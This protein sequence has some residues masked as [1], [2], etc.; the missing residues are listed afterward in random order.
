MT[1]AVILGLLGAG[2]AFALIALVAVVR[3]LNVRRDA[4]EEWR[5]RRANGHPSVDGVD[6]ARFRRAYLRAHGPR[7]QFYVL[8]AVAAA[9][10]STPVAAGP[11]VWLWRTITPADASV[12]PRGWSFEGEL[13]WLFFLYFNIIAVWAAAALVASYFYHRGRPGGFD[14]ELRRTA[15]S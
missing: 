8:A 3:A 5:A 12:G 2:A 6:E 14:E 15:A 11:L 13:V 4:G 10:A 9:A 1:L 7:G